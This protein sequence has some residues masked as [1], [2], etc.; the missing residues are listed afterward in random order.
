[1]SKLNNIE[2]DIAKSAY[3][4]S[5]SINLSK[6]NII[7]TSSQNEAEMLFSD[8]K[9][10]LDKDKLL[11]LPCT[12]TLPY[13]N[14]SPQ[15]ETSAKRISTLID[16]SENIKTLILS[17]DSYFQKIIP[18]NHYKKQEIIVSKN[19]ALN[20]DELKEK[21]NS[22]HYIKTSMVEHPGQY[23]IHE[24]VLDFFPIHHDTPF[25]IEY[26]NNKIK[27]IK[28]F[29]PSTQLSLLNVKNI[30]IFPLKEII[31]IDNLN[32]TKTILNKKL[33]ELN[34]PTRKKNEINKRFENHSLSFNGAENLVPLI[35]NELVSISESFNNSKSYIFK[36][37]KCIKCYSKFIKLVNK[38]YKKLNQDHLISSPETVYTHFSNA[39]S[40]IYNSKIRDFYSE[41]TNIINNQ[42]IKS[43]QHANHS[44]ENHPINRIVQ[45]YEKTDYKIVFLAN[46]GLRENR[47]VN[48]LKSSPHKV[49]KYKNNFNSFLNQRNKEFI[50]ILSGQLNAGI[51]LKSEKLV[52]I[53]EQEVFSGISKREVKKNTVINLKKLLGT[54]SMLNNGDYIVHEDYGIGIYQGL[55]SLEVGG[56][57]GEFLQLD[58]ADSKLF[59]PVQKI[60]RVQKYTGI[61]GKN[62]TLDKLGSKKWIST[63]QKVEKSVSTI[64]GDLIKL[65]AKRENTRCWTADK[66]NHLDN[67][68]A[69]LFPY[70]ETEDQLKAINDCLNDLSNN[71]PMDRLVCGDVGFGKTEVALRAAFKAAMSGKQ[72]AII[73][74]TTILADQHL[75]TFTERLSSFPI[76]VAGLSRFYS[77]KENDTTI[78][79]LKKG[80]VDVII[81]THKLIQ[82]NIEFKDLGLLIIDEEHRFGVKQKELLKQ[83][84]NQIHVMTL[85][86]TPIPRTLYMSLINIRDISVI[87]TPPTDRQTI[88]TFIGSYEEEIVMDAILKETKRN[89]QVFFVHNRVK[90]IA[91]VTHELKE[92]LP[93]VSFEFAHGKMDS[94]QI[95]DI[96][97]RFSNKEF[98]V[99]VTTTIIESGI[100]LPNVN[101]LIIDRADSLGLAQL[102]Q[103]RGRVGRSS[104][105]AY[106]YLLVPE[107]KK[108]TFDAKKR[109]EALRSIDDL[110]QGFQLALRDLEIRGAG[111]I[112]GKEQSGSVAL[113]G[114][115]L[116]TKILKSAILNLQNKNDEIEDGLDPEVKIPI[117]AYIPT[118]Y[119][120]EASERLILYQRLG[121]IKDLSSANLMKNEISD[122]FGSPP[123]EVLNYIDIMLVRSKLKKVG[124]IELEVKND[125]LILK[126]NKFNKLD[127]NKILALCDSKKE[128][129]SLGIKNTLKIKCDIHIVQNISSLMEFV[130]NLYKKI[131]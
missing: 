104:R 67:E 102:Y 55:K 79:D 78:N 61:E 20:I 98:D 8:L 115:E 97:H 110:G 56:H 1:M 86:A 52:F 69:D 3:S 2:F 73:A 74:P 118:F 6:S 124:I 58:Y 81:G 87:N 23:S 5:R 90:D 37:D 126:P 26:E 46:T 62:P 82:K 75:Q 93:D 14:I 100:D 66:L 95:E 7:V 13:E 43:F 50:T 34:I 63:K 76:R 27:R 41:D 108:V 25:R 101:T 127:I 116:Y 72:V 28:S 71:K 109:L 123:P 122:R 112:L 38:R 83:Y 53:S 64:A 65:Y 85:T 30:K 44:L 99:L 51:K 89:G 21:I 92:L 18:T 84:K 107:I 29:N 4:L 130:D 94:K 9:L 16:F 11:L 105:K 35:Y 54:L 111:N 129:F 114:Y 77:K 120:P 17:V 24:K 39:D 113:I 32:E 117:S 106:A 103:L 42:D 68:F 131:V 125:T 128:I 96:I 45:Y 70:N 121:D 10:F 15:L 40:I 47:I 48:I 12:D 22:F 19:L 80:K 57:K 33:S 119:I 31:S 88:K 36:A 59:L 49:L 60:G 91:L